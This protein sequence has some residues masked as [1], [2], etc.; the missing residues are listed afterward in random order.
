MHFGTSNL[1]KEIMKHKHTQYKPKKQDSI[2]KAKKK[3]KN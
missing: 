2:E 3:K 1:L